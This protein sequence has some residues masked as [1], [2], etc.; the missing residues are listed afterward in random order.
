MAH[1]ASGSAA[2][3]AQRDGRLLF[4]S[5]GYFAC[6]WCHVMQR[7]SFRNPDIAALLNRFTVPVKVDRELQPALDA[8]LIEFVRETRGHAGWPLNVFLTP[9]GFPL[10]GLVYA[11]PGTSWCWCRTC[12]APGARIREL[13]RLARAAA[14]ELHGQD[15]ATQGAAATGRGPAGG[16]RGGPVGGGR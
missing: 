2:E 3:Q 16:L 6:H 14:Q 8:Q 9:E 12:N 5:S 1:L 13:S 15:G 7:E 11:P 4:I 10:L